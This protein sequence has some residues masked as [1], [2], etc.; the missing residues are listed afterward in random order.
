MNDVTEIAGL[1][2]YPLPRRGMLMT[3]LISGFT[4][5]TQRVEAQVIHTDTTGLDAGEIQ[6]PT[7]DGKLPAYYARPAARD[8][9]RS[10]W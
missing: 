4:L 6:I 10:S 7:T 5:A 1:R 8:R 3:G 2:D 9:S